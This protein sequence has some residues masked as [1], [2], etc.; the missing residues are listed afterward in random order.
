[1]STRL[2][3]VVWALQSGPTAANGNITVLENAFFK[4]V[5]PYDI[6]LE[7][8]LGERRRLGIAPD[9]AKVWRERLG[10]QVM[11]VLVNV[12]IPVCPFLAYHLEGVDFKATFCAWDTRTVSTHVKADL[13]LFTVAFGADA[14]AYM[15]LSPPE[16]VK[17]ASEAYDACLVFTSRAVSNMATAQLSASGDDITSRVRA[18]C[19]G[20]GA[21][22]RTCEELLSILEAMHTAR[23]RGTALPVKKIDTLAPSNLGEFGPFFTKYMARACPLFEAHVRGAAV[24]AN[25]KQIAAET[26]VLARVLD[27]RLP[28]RTFDELIASID[29][30]VRALKDRPI[31]FDGAVG[32]HIV[33]ALGELTAELSASRFDSI[34]AS[35]YADY[36]LSVITAAF[37]AHVYKSDSPTARVA[38]ISLSDIQMQRSLEELVKKSVEAF[39]RTP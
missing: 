3:E 22:T 4:G 6:T 5:A 16:M 25:K 1:M 19:S 27:S 26:S 23:I 20:S 29:V 30:C 38:L 17:C 9:T 21:N 7:D 12:L 39:I 10:P 36:A 32:P 2:Q 35:Q 24:A 37:Q 15:P 13:E 8:V 34:Y 31:P 33:R 14:S 18:V 11:L 28:A